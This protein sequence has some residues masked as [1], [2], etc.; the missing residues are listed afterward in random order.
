MIRMAPVMGALALT[1]NDS[2]H[3]VWGQ[4]E[5]DVLPNQNTTTQEYMGWAQ[6]VF[7]VL[8]ASAGKSDYEVHLVTLG[9]IYDPGVIGAD[10]NRVR[11]AFF[12][13]PS[14]IL[15]LPG[16]QAT[17]RPAAHHY[18][19]EHRDLFHVTPCES[20][21]LASRIA[22]GILTPGALPLRSSAAP[23]L[24][25]TT[26]IVI[27]T[28]VAL[29]PVPFGQGSNKFFEVSVGGASLSPSDFEI[30]TAGAALI[31]RVPAGGLTPTNFSVRHVAGSGDALDWQTMPTLVDAVLGLPLE[32]F[33]AP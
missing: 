11:D 3:I 2:L 33:V 4:G 9:A 15:P 25:G 20:V 22:D 29:A 27:Q 23:T 5:S 31:V 17:I 7:A 1:A 26:D 14:N 16:M 8:A 6:I 30:A 18:D 24:V 13:M 21:A 19:L 32:P 10:M 28:T 12:G